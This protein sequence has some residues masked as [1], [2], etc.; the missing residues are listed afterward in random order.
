MSTRY[1]PIEIDGVIYSNPSQA[2][3][4]L[5][6]SRG[7]I[8][9][10]MKQR[11]IT[12]EEA[13]RLYLGKGDSEKVLSCRSVTYKGETYNSIHEGCEQLGKNYNTIMYRLSRYDITFE[14]AIDFDKTR[15]PGLDFGKFRFESLKQ[16]CRE[17]GVDYNRTYRRMNVQGMS[18]EE[19]IQDSVKVVYAGIEYSSLYEACNK[20][21]LNYPSTYQRMARKGIT[22]EETLEISLKNKLEEEKEEA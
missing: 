2:A 20:L 13:I 21:G 1:E 15:C 22:A 12:F 4:T 19:A 3:Q 11:E 9:S 5:G 17:L 10:I 8:Y 16:A 18:F 14:Q 7:T 6:V